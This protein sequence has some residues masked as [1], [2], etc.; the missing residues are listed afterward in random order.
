MVPGTCISYNQKMKIYLVGGA[1]RDELLGR[2]I[3]ERDWV[4][5]GSSP[6]EML[7]LGYQPVG[8]DFPV[9]LHPETHEEYA[10]ARTERK[11]GRGYQ[12]FEFYADPT[13]SLEDDLKRRDLTINAIARDE[14]GTLIDPYGGQQDLHNKVF[15]HV[16]EAFAEDPVRI[17]RL[18]RFAAKLPDF[19]LDP[20]T[21]TLM[22]NMVANGEVDALVAERVWQEFNRALTE[23]APQRF[24]EVLRNCGACAI[25]FPELEN[26]AVNISKP[27][28]IATQRFALLLHQLDKTQIQA[29]CKRFKVPSDYHD[30]ALQVQQHSAAYKSLDTC[31][32]KDIL[33][34]IKNCDALRRPKRFAETIDVLA[35]IHNIN[36]RKLL[37][38]A[39]ECITKID[40]KPL[41]DQKLVGRDFADA[42]ETL[43]LESITKKLLA[44]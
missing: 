4:V 21:N 20:S 32:A 10:L 44:F 30:L 14:D 27:H 26:I 40:T 13:V 9:F 7:K 34:L 16:S 31:N 37:N 23:A 24:F 38:S 1:V 11:V 35:H 25:L 8:K 28:F 15:K 22:Q 29:L 42:L 2:P 6:A 12:G 3:K 36:H 5:V 41:Q 43:Q 18:A 33:T 17:L 39:L 19:T